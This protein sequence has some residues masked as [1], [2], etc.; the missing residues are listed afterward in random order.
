MS[1][2]RIVLGT[3]RLVFTP[4]EYQRLRPVTEL[5]TAIHKALSM[6]GTFTAVV[7]GSDFRMM[8][9]YVLATMLSESRGGQPLPAGTVVLDLESG[10]GDIPGLDIL[11]RMLDDPLLAPNRQMSMY[12]SGALRDAVERMEKP[13]IKQNGRSADYLRHDPTKKH[14][15]RG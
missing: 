4:M 3:G 9:Q 5:G 12:A 15:R 11:Q 1:S 10:G 13:A 2:D 6:D 7:T 8:E 14:R